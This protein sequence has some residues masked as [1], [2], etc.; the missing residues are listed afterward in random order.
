M[1]RFIGMILILG[2]AIACGCSEKQQLHGTVTFADD[3]AP[4][5]V[6]AVYF[7]TPT[8]EAV[9]AI[10]KDGTYIVSSTGH[11]DGIPKGE[12]YKV[13]VVGADIVENTTS[14]G[15]SAGGS[16]RTPLV[17]PKY[18]NKDTSG[19]TFTAD[20]TR[21]FDLTLERAKPGNKK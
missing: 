4:V 20:G 11:N 12:T 6:G 21:R 17:D 7:S 8:F 16:K 9:G 18:R 1:K 19:L 10:K 14:A 2:A 5:P 15:G 3:G 13:S